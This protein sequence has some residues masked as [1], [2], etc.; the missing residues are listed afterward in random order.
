MVHVIV[1]FIKLVFQLLYN[2]QDTGN[3]GL[4]AGKKSSQTWPLVWIRCRFTKDETFKIFNCASRKGGDGT[5]MWI[6][7]TNYEIRNFQN[8]EFCSGRRRDGMGIPQPFE[9]LSVPGQWAKWLQRLDYFCRITKFDSIRKVYKLIWST[10]IY[11]SLCSKQPKQENIWNRLSSISPN[12]ESK[13]IKDLS[14]LCLFSPPYRRTRVEVWPIKG[15]RGQVL[16]GKD[17][18]LGTSSFFL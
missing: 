3:T 12:M 18:N 4:C 13:A 6:W 7:N 10:L 14:S 16:F 5:G 11:F 8:G 17:K 9:C 2:L 15:V 1:I